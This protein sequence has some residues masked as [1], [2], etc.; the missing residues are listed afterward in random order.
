MLPP[1]DDEVLR[2]NPAFANLYST[3][4]N[5]LLNPDG[6]T[7]HDAAAEERAAVRQELDR[8]RLST[9]KNRLLEHALVTASTDRRQQPALPEPLLQLLLLL[10]SILD[11]DKPLSPEST[12]LL[13]ASPPLSDL[14][15]HLPHL[16]ALASSSLHASALGLARVCHP[17]TNPSFLHRHIPSLPESYTSLRT[18]L[19]TAQRTLTASRMRILAALNRLLGCYTQSLVHLVRSLEAKHGVVARSLELRA[20]DVCLRAQRTDV[21]ASIAVQD[22]TRELYTPQALAALQNYAHCLK[23]VRLR[24]TDRVRGLRAELGEHDVGVAGQEEKEKT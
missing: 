15:T 23:D 14:E 20:S 10:P 9:A 16:A 21:E 12:S 4:T 24:M 6:S 2:E 11:V 13:L 8:R 17:T 19:A 22:L 3:L 5:G 1:V 7:R 18:N